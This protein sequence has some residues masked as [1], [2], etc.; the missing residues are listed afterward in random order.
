MTP[1]AKLAVGLLFTGCAGFID[2]V[3]FVELGG[4]F[5]SF[6]SGNTTRLGTA[7]QG[8]WTVGVALPI[9]LIVM[10]FAG[11][12]AGSLLA[13]GGRR[14]G[15]VLALALVLTAV[16]VSIGLSLAGFSAGEAMV[17]LAFAGGAQNTVLPSAGA[18]RL[19]ATFVTGTLFAASQ[20]LARAV[21]REAP[22]WRWTQHIAVW[23]SLCVGAAFGAIG[24]NHWGIPALLVP[25]VIYA[26][27]LADFV[28][29]PRDGTPVH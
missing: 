17:A 7:L 16:L 5:I 24:D 29:R 20:D 10:F 1:P 26:C 22:P 2:A 27:F 28:L 6:M 3:V 9:A 11:G 13:F 14:W 15:S 21:R 8:G 19:G 18:A 4:Y 25:A 23:G 12:F